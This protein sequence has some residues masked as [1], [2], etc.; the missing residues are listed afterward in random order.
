MSKL[1][2]TI[3]RIEKKTN[4]ILF[5]N[6]FNKVTIGMITNITAKVDS[7]KTSFE[8]ARSHINAP[9][10]VT[11]YN[12]PVSYLFGNI[13]DLKVQLENTT[14]TISSIENQMN[15]ETKTIV[16]NFKNLETPFG[17]GKNFL[18]FEYFILFAPLAILLGYIYCSIRYVDYL[19]YYSWM[20]EQ[21]K[22]EDK[23][24]PIAGFRATWPTP[25]ESF[26]SHLFWIIPIM[27]YL[28]SVILNSILLVNSSFNNMVVVYPIFPIL[29]YAIG[30]LIFIVYICSVA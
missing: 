19:R 20:K 14:K 8:K 13:T 4:E 21:V 6:Q 7:L 29:L 24:S 30:F 5:Y 22:N 28:S 1:D 23:E 17:F 3:N 2:E 10:N 12:K 26:Y 18:R 27:L 16:E 25:T 11:S 15:N 9:N